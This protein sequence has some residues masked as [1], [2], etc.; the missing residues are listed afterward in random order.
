MLGNIIFLFF[1]CGKEEQEPFVSYSGAA[2]QTGHCSL[3]STDGNLYIVGKRIPDLLIIKTDLDGRKIWERTFSITGNGSENAGQQIIETHDHCFVVSGGALNHNFLLKINESGDSL[4]T[5]AFTENDQQFFA[6]T[7]ELSDQTILVAKKEKISFDP[8]EYRLVFFQFSKV[9]ELLKIVTQPEI[10][11]S[12]LQLFS[13]RNTTGENLEITCSHDSGAYL[14]TISPMLEVV[15]D[16]LIFDAPY[17]CNF[18]NNSHNFMIGTQSGLNVLVSK[19]IPQSSIPFDW[20][21]P[22][23]A[24]EWVDLSWIEPI[25][26]GYMITGLLW[27]EA[28]KGYKVRHPFCLQIDEEGNQ[29]WLWYNIDNFEVWGFPRRFHFINNNHYLLVGNFHSEQILVWRIK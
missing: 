15:G 20:A 12:D 22:L 21:Y 2:G 6:A 25:P 29:T 23:P 3:V 27:F 11:P 14:L 26:V 24:T 17:Y 13:W 28:S 1:S 10:Y 8:E 9:G 19:I 18:S 4:W 5:Y 16:E 7:A